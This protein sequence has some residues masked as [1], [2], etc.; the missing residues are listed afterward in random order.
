MT[1]DNQYLVAGIFADE[2]HALHAIQHLEE[3]GFK[4]KHIHYSPHKSGANILDPLMHLGF[5]QEEAAYYN[6]EFQRGRTIVTVKDDTRQQ[7]AAAIMQRDGASFANGR[8]SQTAGTIDRARQTAGTTEDAQRLRLREEQLQVTKTPTQVGAVGLHKEVV[9]EQQR[10]NVPVSHEEVYIERRAGSGQVSDMPIGEGESIRVPVSAEQV[11]VTKQT[12]DTGE[13]SIGKRKVQ[14]TQQVTD[15][16][17]HEEAHIEH[18]GDV[19]V[20][21]NDTSGVRER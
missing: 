4:G 3:A 11:N 18:Q 14:G 8:A 21:G 7:E 9:S 16:V 15:T 1:I 13:V 10:I 12:V 19:T 17:R 5:V 20:E 6:N 2:Q